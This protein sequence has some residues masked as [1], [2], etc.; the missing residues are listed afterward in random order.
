MKKIINLLAA[1]CLLALVGC[2]YDNYDEPKSILSGRAVYNGEAISVRTNALRFSLYQD[3]YAFMSEIPAY[4]AQDGT[5]SVSLFDGEYKLVRM[6]GAPWEAKQ[7]DTIHISVKGNTVKDI[8]V[9]PFFTISNASFQKNGNKI[10][11]TFTVNKV[12]SYAS[13]K[14]VSVYLGKSI[15]TD[16]NVKEASISLDLSNIVLGEPKTI[17]IDIPTS[18]QSASSIYARVGVQSD[19]ANEFCYTQIERVALK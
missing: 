17:E 9:T 4:I 13:L 14:S 12:V 3:G 18:L 10:A 2:S 19:Q 5:F 7:N 15:L 1:V 16:N 6:A 8:E 11:A